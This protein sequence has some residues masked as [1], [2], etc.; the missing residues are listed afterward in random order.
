VS[1]SPKASRTFARVFFALG[2]GFFVASAPA[3]SV[4]TTATTF[5]SSGPNFSVATVSFVGFVSSLVIK[6]LA[7]IAL[8]R[9]AS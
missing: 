1:E 6:S 3:I 2:N 4:F 8:T 7:P 5:K 9:R